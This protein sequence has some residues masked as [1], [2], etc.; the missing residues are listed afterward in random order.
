MIRTTVLR[1]A[2]ALAATLLMAGCAGVAKIA[3][4][5]RSANAIDFA[6]M[7]AKDYTIPDAVWNLRTEFDYFVEVRNSTEQRLFDAAAEALRKEGYTVSFSDLTART[8][9]AERGLGLWEWSSITAVY[10]KGADGV[11]K[12][13]IKN[14]ITQDV[15]GSW[16][17]N[18]AQDVAVA[19]CKL[20]E[21]N[22]SI[23]APPS[24]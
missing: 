21:C 12:V 23:A 5:P 14:A 15:T 6:A 10:Y 22:A 19:L 4:F 9:I 8:V 1:V 18:R 13:Y 24:K 2:L 3:D 11:L 7:Q 16:R 17:I 20:V